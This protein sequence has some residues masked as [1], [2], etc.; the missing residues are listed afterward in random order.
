M[1]QGPSFVGTAYRVVLFAHPL[2]DAAPPELKDSDWLDV[3]I[4]IRLLWS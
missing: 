1:Q 3:S 4:N 2:K